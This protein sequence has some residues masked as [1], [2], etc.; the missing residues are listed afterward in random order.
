MSGY[1][2]GHILPIDPQHRRRPPRDLG[3]NFQQASCRFFCTVSMVEVTQSQLYFLRSC[4]KASLSIYLSVYV[5]VNTNPTIADEIR[6][7]AIACKWSIG[8]CG[9]VELESVIA[10]VN[11][12][13]MVY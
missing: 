7:V 3:H 10:Q 11:Y 5:E 9:R 8:S 13:S 1:L 4:F 12:F 2:P 6:M